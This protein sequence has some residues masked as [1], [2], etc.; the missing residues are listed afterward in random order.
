MVSQSHM[1]GIKM[2]MV[3]SAG[4]LL[5]RRSAPRSGMVVDEEPHCKQNGF[6]SST[7][8]KDQHQISNG[9][10]QIT[11]PAGPAL[12]WKPKPFCE[13]SW[14]RTLRTLDMFFSRI[15]SL[16]GSPVRKLEK[17]HVCAPKL[18]RANASVRV[19]AVKMRRA[20]TS[21]INMV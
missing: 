6:V 1:L 12:R 11:S 17:G 5:R 3:R 18:L 14:L 10:K 19:S 21:C 7:V 15:D 8:Y 13:T 20:I 9:S 2:K 4:M 16:S